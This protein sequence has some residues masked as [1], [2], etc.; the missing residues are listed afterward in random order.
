MPQ[1]WNLLQTRPVMQKN[2]SG[3]YSSEAEDGMPSTSYWEEMGP[4]LGIG[5]REWMDE[6]RSRERRKAV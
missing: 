6:C 4:P 1:L 3:S 2:I 5:L